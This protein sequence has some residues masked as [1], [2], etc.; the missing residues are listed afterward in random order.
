MEP[1]PFAQANVNLTSSQPN[2]R[3]LPAHDTGHEFISCWMLTH[4]EIHQI[5]QTGR[6]WLRVQ[7]Q[8]HPPVPIQ[9]SSP[10]DLPEDQDPDDD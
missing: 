4:P 9:S 3:E 1:I 2:T 10:F 6:I 5:T 8:A 7:S